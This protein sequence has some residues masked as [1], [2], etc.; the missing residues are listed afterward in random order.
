MNDF[1]KF[2]LICLAATAIMTGLAHSILDN[3]FSTPNLVK[4]QIY[5]HDYTHDLKTGK[6][7]AAKRALQKAINNNPE[8]QSMGGP[9]KLSAKM[10]DL[11]EQ[12]SAHQKQKDTESSEERTY[13]Y[14]TIK[15]AIIFLMVMFLVISAIFVVT[16]IFDESDKL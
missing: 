16:S 15:G 11:Q 10:I 6:L 4:A 9:K 8:G 2:S 3:N 12:I 13:Y 14:D 1:T 5:Y 7:G